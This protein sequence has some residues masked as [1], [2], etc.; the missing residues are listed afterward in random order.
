MEARRVAEEESRRVEDARKRAEALAG[1][2][3]PKAGSGSAGATAQAPGSA[4]RSN[5][6]GTAGKDSARSSQRPAT[7]LTMTPQLVAML[8]A[9][10][11][12]VWD[13]SST[14]EDELSFQEWDV[15]TIIQA[16]DDDGWLI[17]E[18]RGRRGLVPCTHL[19]DKITPLSAASAQPS[20]AAKPPSQGSQPPPQGSEP[21]AQAQARAPAQPIQPQ[22]PSQSQV[23]QASQGRDVVVDGEG[24]GMN[25]PPELV[26]PQQTRWH[27]K[28]IRFLK[29]S[30][31]YTPAYK[32]PQTCA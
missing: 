5:P 26:S 7:G 13:Y 29:Y 32:L 20:Q 19:E 15:L 25:V 12:A 18:L 9:T 1:A 8:P 4:T 3:A 27:I 23:P 22:A 17:A 21:P 10:C 16:S 14:Q 2:G 30:G 31:L 11:V 24:A 6:A 28:C